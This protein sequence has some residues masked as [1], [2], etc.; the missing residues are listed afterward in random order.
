MFISI[1]GVGIL[2]AA[3]AGCLGCA[4]SSASPSIA[5]FLS[6]KYMQ[7]KRMQQNF[8]LILEALILLLES[9]LPLFLSWRPPKFPRYKNKHG[10]TH[11]MLL[12]WYL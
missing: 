5:S 2:F 12:K 10:R 11:P 6:E 8:L 4:S 1:T 7:I 9:L 3:N